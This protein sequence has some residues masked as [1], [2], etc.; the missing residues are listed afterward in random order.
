MPGMLGSVPGSVQ[1]GHD[2][3]WW[4]YGI[5]LFLSVRNTKGLANKGKTIA[6]CPTIDCKWVFPPIEKMGV[7][8]QKEMVEGE[9]TCFRN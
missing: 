2:V 5:Q 9:E 8:A 4:D 6:L 7:F 1:G 3:R